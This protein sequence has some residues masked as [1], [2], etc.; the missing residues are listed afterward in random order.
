[1]AQQPE[2]TQEQFLEWEQNPVTKVFFEDIQQRKSDLE[3]YLG[4]GSFL[5][6]Q[7]PMKHAS[8]SKGRLDVYNDILDTRWEDEVS[9]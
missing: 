3:Q 7:D 6:E 8:I 4:E 2:I 1:M 5:Q 9:E